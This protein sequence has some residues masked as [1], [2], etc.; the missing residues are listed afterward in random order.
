MHAGSNPAARTSQSQSPRSPY[1][2]A[3]RLFSYPVR[4]L[5]DFPPAPNH[6]MRLFASHTSPPIQLRYAAFFPISPLPVP[7]SAPT[8]RIALFDSPFRAA[9]RLGLTRCRRLPPRVSFPMGGVS[10]LTLLAPL[11]CPPNRLLA[12][13]LA[14]LSA[15]R[16]GVS[17]II[18]FPIRRAGRMRVFRTH[19]FFPSISP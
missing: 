19:I 14:S 3:G 2:G 18:R 7:L 11:R 5:D 9:I 1:R 17:P 8:H 12:S 10:Q 16:L 6:D 15:G 4:R 13:L